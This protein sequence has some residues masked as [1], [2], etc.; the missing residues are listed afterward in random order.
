MQ[1]FFTNQIDGGFA[2]FTEEEARHC[3][4]VLRKKEGAPLQFVDGKGTFYEGII[5]ETGKRHIIAKIIGQRP[6]FEEPQPRLHIAVAPTK[7]MDRY[8][9]FLEKATEIGISQLTPLHCEHSERNRIRPDR[10]EKILLSAMKQSI[11]ATLPTFN[12]LTDFE[13]FIKKIAPSGDGQRFIA[14]CRQP[15][16]PHLFNNCMPDKDVTILIGP[17]GDFSEGEIKLAETN[18]FQSI[19]LGKSRLRTETAALAACHIFN[20][21]NSY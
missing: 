16:L 13:A 17:E 9:W 1:L 7:N 4:Q 2:H 8:E 10:M 18:G 20:L 11:R 19:S 21:K 12:E 5:S 14:H 6:E 15:N 3:L